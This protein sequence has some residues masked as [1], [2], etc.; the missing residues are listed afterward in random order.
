MA[1]TPQPSPKVS[2]GENRYFQEIQVIEMLGFLPRTII[3]S[4]EEG[5]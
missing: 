5:G 3:L 4:L 2:Q 1:L